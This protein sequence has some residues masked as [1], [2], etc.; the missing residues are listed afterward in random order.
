M[1]QMNAVQRASEDAIRAAVLE[2]EARMAGM[3]PVQVAQMNEDQ[4]LREL[5]YKSILV[6]NAA[7]IGPEAWRRIDDRSTQI[8]RD[9]LAVFSRLRAA[10]M[11]PVSMGDILSYFAQ[12]SDDGEVTTS[13]DGRQTGR[14]DQAHVKFVGTP[15]PIYAAETRFG[16]RQMA[17]MQ[18]AGMMLDT[19]S[20][21]NKV[22]KI[23][24]KLEDVALNG[25]ASIVVAGNTLTGLRNHPSRNTASHGLTL[26][27]ATGAQW[28][29]MIKSAVSL[30][31]GDNAFQPVTFFL[32]YA[33]W[34]AMTST[35]YS[36]AYPK[37]IISVLREIEQVADFVPASRV[38]ANNV[39]GIAGL[40]GGEWGSV[41][42]GMSITTRPKARHNTED[43]YVYTTMAA[44]AL[45]LRTDYDGRMPICHLVT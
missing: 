18:K 31:I 42:E 32:N 24:E 16:W 17:T 22:R 41:L 35:E 29:A 43:D 2:H 26:A 9:V 44:A 39:I 34:F 15:V 14:S 33:D 27:T 11:T 3:D 7:P 25:D 19:V 45:Q 8:M 30:L 37:K 40:A 38:P 36:T 20:I 13:M 28:D 12:V 5:N 23:A 10:S 6:G 21:A 1:F 4:L